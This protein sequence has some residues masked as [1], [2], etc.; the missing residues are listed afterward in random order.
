M[1]MSVLHWHMP[2]RL[3]ELKSMWL[4]NDGP[5]D[6][7]DYAKKNWVHYTPGTPGVA[8]TFAFVYNV[9]PGLESGHWHLG[10]HGGR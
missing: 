2:V 9:H 8:P 6:L 10:D 7:V 1:C 3:F 5:K 4:A